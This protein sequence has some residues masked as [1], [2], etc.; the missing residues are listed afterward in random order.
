M[1]YMIMASEL[2][3]QPVT[4]VCCTSQH[5]PVGEELLGMQSQECSSPNPISVN[6]RAT[7]FGLFQCLYLKNLWGKCEHGEIF[8]IICI[9]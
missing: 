1:G 9:P 5:I 7:Y 8:I 2:N 6:S 3:R 4:W